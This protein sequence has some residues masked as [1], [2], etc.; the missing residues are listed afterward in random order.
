MRHFLLPGAVADLA[1]GVFAAAWQ[2]R[3][4]ALSCGFEGLNA[5]PLCAVTG[6]VAL[7]TVAVA[8]DQYRCATAGAKIVSS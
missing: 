1:G 3:L 4:I 2:A 6:T 8:A 7:T 5:G